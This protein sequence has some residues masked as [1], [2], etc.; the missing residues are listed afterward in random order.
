M[1]PYEVALQE[2]NVELK[3]YADVPEVFV[4][5]NRWRTTAITLIII[6]TYK[7]VY[8]LIGREHVN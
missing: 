1:G 2:I 5:Y 6:Y 8:M 3:Y 4:H 7:N